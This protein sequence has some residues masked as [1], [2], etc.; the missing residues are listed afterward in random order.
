MVDAWL[1]DSIDC[2]RRCLRSF[3]VVCSCEKSWFLG[4]LF[5][6]KSRLAHSAQLIPDERVSKS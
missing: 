2:G 3:E 1:I 5:Q 4:S 6:Q